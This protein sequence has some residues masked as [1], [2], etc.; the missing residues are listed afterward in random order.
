MAACAVSCCASPLNRDCEEI[1]RACKGIGTDE[2]KI[3]ELLGSK[4]A[5]QRKEIKETYYAMYKEDLCKRLESELHGKLQKAVVLL[6]QEPADRDA[7]IA[8]DA[9]EKW[10]TDDRALTEVICT[11][12]STEIVQIREAYLNRYQRYLEEDVACK[13]QGPFQKLLLALLKA[14]RCE[15]KAVDMEQAKCD[16]KRLYEAGEGRCG[17]DEET[18]IQIFSERS[19]PQLRATFGCYKMEYGHDIMKALKK[20]TQGEFEDALRVT[21]KGMYLPAHYFA[22][23]LNRGM[24]GLLNDESAITRVMVTRA[25]VDLK[26]INLVFERKYKMS[27]VQA[28]HKELSGHFKNFCLTLTVRAGI[29]QQLPQACGCN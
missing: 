6:M 5:Q 23:V 18:I 20:E 14:H 11:R 19:M 25:E 27:L 3:I 28:F 29:P 21:I 13:T 24:K 1:H 17:T 8:R 22:Q 7:M 12:S 2:E 4:N 9:L 15:C 10:C 16:A 26:E